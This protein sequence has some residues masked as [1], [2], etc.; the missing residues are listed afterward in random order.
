MKALYDVVWDWMTTTGSVVV[1]GV[2]FW[3][4]FPKPLLQIAR[5]SHSWDGV[6]WGLGWCFL[7]LTPLVAPARGLDWLNLENQPVVS[8]SLSHTR[9]GSQASRLCAKSKTSRLWDKMTRYVDSHNGIICAARGAGPA[10]KSG[11]K[12]EENGICDSRFRHISHR[13][14]STLLHRIG[15]GVW[16]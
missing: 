14:A 7:G 4:S 5:F 10:A 11:F 1:I 16:G 13:P 9:Y 2:S 12:K 6:W 8:Q 3:K 15:K